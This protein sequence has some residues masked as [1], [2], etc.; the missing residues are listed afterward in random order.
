[1]KKILLQGYY[2][3]DNLGDDY[4]LLSI[5]DSLKNI[6]NIHIDCLVSKNVYNFFMQKYKYRLNILPE[7]IIIRT[8][9]IFWK[10]K[11]GL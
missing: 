2:G 8:V 5:I 4:I 7:R 1:M 11:R 6:D 3:E 9:R 10:R